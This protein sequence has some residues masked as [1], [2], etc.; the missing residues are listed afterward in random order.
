M[1]AA[2]PFGLTGQVIESQY[3]V[4]QPIGEGGFSVVYKGHHLG[5]N[6]PVAIKC[7]KLQAQPYLDSPTIESFLN[8]FRD[9]SRIMYRLSQGNLDIVRAISSGSA[10]SPLLNTLVPYM[11]LEWL[12][13]HSL[14]YDFRER[15]AQGKTGRTLEEVIDLFDPAATAIAYAHSQGVVHRDIKP[16]NLFLT[17]TRDGRRLKVLDFGL[18][19][20]LDEGIGFA[21][22]AQTIGAVTIC[23]PSYGAP[24]Q[25]DSAA[26]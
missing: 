7:L 6:E 14:G 1:A 11:V 4:E 20:I 24:E 25:F 16:G 15:R 8:R 23:S 9:E 17:H 13:G 22:T 26:G 21:P 18:A 3:C 10:V 5:L 19:K 2:D 12:D